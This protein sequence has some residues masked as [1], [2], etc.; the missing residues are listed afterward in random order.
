MN[1]ILGKAL[2]HISMSLLTL[3]QEI[4]DYKNEVDNIKLQLRKQDRHL[5]CIEYHL[6]CICKPFVEA[7]TSVHD[8][9]PVDLAFIQ[10]E[11][12]QFMIVQLYL[13]S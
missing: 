4:I 3:A 12:E 13:F 6:M 5:E 11:P 9:T 8:P 1:S 2:E 10:N 7:A